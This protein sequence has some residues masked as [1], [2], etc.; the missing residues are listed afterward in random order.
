MTNRNYTEDTQGILESIV[1]LIRRLD[2]QNA[3][4][5]ISIR[6]QL[7]GV[8]RRQEEI[9]AILKNRLPAAE[10]GDYH[11]PALFPH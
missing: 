7:D 8:I 5:H 6:Q 4:D 3:A 1:E 9:I 11:I 2:G 10:V